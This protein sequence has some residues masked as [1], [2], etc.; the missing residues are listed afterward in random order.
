MAIVM[1]ALIVPNIAAGSTG[2][3]PGVRDLIL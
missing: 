3:S 2:I 1:I